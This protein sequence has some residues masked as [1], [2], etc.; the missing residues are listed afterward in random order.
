MNKQWKEDEEN[1]LKVE[2]NGNWMDRSKNM[3]IES[4]GTD[5]K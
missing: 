4:E 5:K 1:I 2:E 3:N